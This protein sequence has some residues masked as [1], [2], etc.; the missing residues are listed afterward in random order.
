MIEQTLESTQLG[1]R[2]LPAQLGQAV[3]A[4]S[5][6]GLTFDSVVASEQAVAQQPIETAVQVAGIGCDSA[7]TQIDQVEPDTVAVAV[8]SG[9]SQEN[10][11][12]D[13]AKRLGHG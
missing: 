7:V 12:I 3:V 1:A 10:E 2:S 4:S 9:Q 13:R 8:S 11:E 6:I 5:R